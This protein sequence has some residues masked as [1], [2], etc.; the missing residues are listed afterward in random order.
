MASATKNIVPSIPTQSPAAQ[1]STPDDPRPHDPG[2]DDDDD[3]PVRSYAKSNLEL[4]AAF[5][6]YVVSQG[7]SPQTVKTY[8]ETTT[9]FVESLN[10]ASAVEAGR[11][12]IRKFLGDLLGRGASANTLRKHTC[13]L[14]SL[15]PGRKS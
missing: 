10:S 5:S 7:F 12:A 8:S 1:F 14:G 11:P 6:S 15:V 3:S 13:A 2:P 9:R 4:S